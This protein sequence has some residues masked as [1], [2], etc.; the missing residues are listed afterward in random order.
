VKSY[1]SAEHLWFFHSTGLRYEGKF[2]FWNV[3]WLFPTIPATTMN[4]CPRCWGCTVGY[5]GYFFPFF[6]FFFFGGGTGAWTPG[7]QF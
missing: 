2:S 3:E 6:F 7:R 4:C 1:Q 5:L